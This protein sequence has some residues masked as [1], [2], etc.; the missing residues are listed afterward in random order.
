MATTATSH[1]RLVQIDYPIR[2]GSFGYSLMVIIALMLERGVA[3][4][5]ASLAFPVSVFLVY[6]HLAFAHARRSR[7]PNHAELNY[8]LVDAVLLGLVSAHIG[9]ALWPSFGLLLAIALNNAFCGGARRLTIAL[10]LFL[11]S[12]LCALAWQPGGFL[13]QTTELVTALS[14]FGMAAYVGAVGLMS[15]WQYQRLLRARDA[16]RRSEEQ[17]RFIAENAGDLVAVLD[18]KGR[19]RYTSGAYLERFDPN[20]IAVGSNWMTLI[21]HSDRSSARQFL[22]SILKSGKSARATLKFLTSAGDVLELQ[23]TGNA[24]E[25]PGS[26]GARRI[27]LISRGRSA[28]EHD[29]ESRFARGLAAHRVDYGLLL[30][31][32]LGRIEFASPRMEGILGHAPTR[33][34]G[35]TMAEIAEAIPASDS[36]MDEVWR[37]MEAGGTCQCKFVLIHRTGLL[38]LAWANIVQL[39]GPDKNTVFYAWTVLEDTSSADVQAALNQSA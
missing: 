22:S 2:V 16:L 1:R 7:D 8:L 17:S 14:A 15:H 36:L 27:V 10:A 4:N 37:S 21:E 30:T 9:L 34:V 31:S 29:L 24:M 35:K 5:V 26:E 18:D 6:P 20:L 28:L 19:V 11:G 32:V 23:T 33:L 39:L 3:L 25:D 12:G 13:P 38:K